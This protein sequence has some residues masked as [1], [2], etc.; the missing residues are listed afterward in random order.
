VWV[1]IE[2]TS[3]LTLANSAVVR[4][5]GNNSRLGQARFFGG[6]YT[7]INNGVI[8]GAVGTPG[9]TATISPN[10]FTNNGQLRQ[11]GL[12]SLNVTNNWSSPGTILVSAGVFIFDGTFT[13]AGMGQL[14]QTGGSV[15]IAGV[16]VN[17]GNTITLNSTT[18]SWTV[19]GGT[20]RN[21][22]F[23]FT[24]GQKLTFTNSSNNRLDGLAIT[25]DLVIDS[26]GAFVGVQNGLTI[27]GAVRVTADNATFGFFG[28]Q[29]F[30]GSLIE[31]LGTNSWISIEGTSTVTLGAGT[32]VR[33]IGNN[34][35]LGQAR[36]FGGTYT[37]I[38]NGVIEGN[39]ASNASYSIQPTN[40]TNNGTLQSLA[41]SLT[42]NANWTSPGTLRYT[43]GQL[44]L[45]G[46][47]TAT[48]GLGP[49]IDAGN[50]SIA[51][52]GTL[53]NS[54]NTITLNATTGDLNLAGGTIRGGTLVFSGRTLLFN[55]STN[56]RLD[57]VSITGD[58][59]LGVA[60]NW[61]GIQNGLT[62]SGAVR[63]TAN[64]TTLGFFG[65]QQFNG[66]LI[67]AT[68]TNAWVSIEGTGT[69]TLSP[70]T[71]VRLTGNN[72]RLGQARTFGGTYSL[73]NNGTVEVNTPAAQSSN[74][75][76]TNFTN[77]GDLNVLANATLNFNTTFQA[78]TGNLT[79][80]AG[81][82]V[83]NNGAMALPAGMTTTI[84]ISGTANT[85]FGRIASTGAVTFA[86]TLRPRFVSFAPSAGNTFNFFTYSSRTGTYGT[87]TPINLPGGLTLTPNY[88][89][90]NLTLSIT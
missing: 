48:G 62:I 49:I 3:T 37:L 50:G 46:T 68:G 40:F 10:N 36:T 84:D 20:I 58:L 24:Q 69:L 59:V 29:T 23:V 88:N 67:E 55:N 57:G 70:T 25:G 83:N 4:L 8:E 76:P 30:S 16:F 12:G 54:G 56:N 42:V 74:I 78:S 87:V 63:L 32:T 14:T 47:L 77:N 51:V 27:S 39:G 82:L 81:G 18:G 45:D 65:V 38:N 5:G 75:S 13:G 41:G 79:I 1:S 6:T 7:L 26:T 72:T 66:S 11:T 35:R 73:V 34:S 90:T 64:D 21:G 71:T 22:T 19:A 2:G 44:L 43:E 33:L 85:Q 31:A 15:Q 52:S 86:G 61:V 53:V 60:S 80:A 9:Q 17:T 89:A 28:T